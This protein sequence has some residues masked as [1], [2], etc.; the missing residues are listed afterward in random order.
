MTRSVFEL[1]IDA[2]GFYGY[3]IIVVTA[4]YAGLFLNALWELFRLY[5]AG[6]DKLPGMEYSSRVVRIFTSLNDLVKLAVAGGF[7]LT[8]VGFIQVIEGFRAVDK[9][10]T[11]DGMSLAVVSSITY[12]PSVIIS[13]TWLLLLRAAVAARPEIEGRIWSKPAPEGK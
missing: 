1:F 7:L 4:T 2:T 5:R 3:V 8:L 6:P 10:S 9:G 11:L 12:V 13:G